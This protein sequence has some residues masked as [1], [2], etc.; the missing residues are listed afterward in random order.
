LLFVSVIEKGR[1]KIRERGMKYERNVG[2]KMPQKVGN[3][4]KKAAKGGEINRWEK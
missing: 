4:T 2:G 1:E 3:V